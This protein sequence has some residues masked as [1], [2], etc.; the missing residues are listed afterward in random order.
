MKRWNRKEKLRE[1][2][3]FENWFS[4][5]ANGWDDGHVSEADWLIA[6]R[7]Q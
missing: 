2:I 6:I 4:K 5:M 1:R 3:R 7:I